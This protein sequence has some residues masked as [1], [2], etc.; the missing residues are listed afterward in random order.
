MLEALGSDAPALG[1]LSKVHCDGWGMSYDTPEGR[2]RLRDVTAAHEST[3]YTAAQTSISATDAIVHLRMATSGLSVCEANTHPFLI[4]SPAGRLA[5]CHNGGL[6]Q[7]PELDELIDADLL[8]G[9][10][11]DT[12]S[13][14]YLAALVSAMRRTGG[15]IVEAYR[16]LLKS[17]IDIRHSSLNALILT[18]TDLFVLSRNVPERRPEGMEPDYYQ[19]QWDV[20]DGVFTAWSSQ[21]RSRPGNMLEDGDLLQVDRASGT[22]TVHRVLP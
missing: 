4:D 8:A 19:L 17:L 3:A 15:D 1:E 13:E 2:V 12:D 5:F 7:G 22:V 11:G 9:L 21:V 18:D 16:L 14:Q 6:K 10:E 20:V